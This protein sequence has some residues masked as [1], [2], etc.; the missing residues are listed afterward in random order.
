MYPQGACRIRKAPSSPTAAQYFKLFKPQD[1]RKRS[2][3]ARRRNCAVLPYPM[4][5]HCSPC[6]KSL[7]VWSAEASMRSA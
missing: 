3:E 2:A 6:G 5:V 4:A 7:Q 1:W